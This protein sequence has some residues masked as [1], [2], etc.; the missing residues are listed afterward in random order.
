MELGAWNFDSKL[1]P[2]THLLCHSRGAMHS[3]HLVGQL[4]ELHF[5][6]GFHAGGLEVLRQ[7]LEVPPDLIGHHRLLLHLLDEGG[8]G[9]EVGGVQRLQDL[10]E[11]DPG[12]SFKAHATNSA[13]L[14][15]TDR[16]TTEQPPPKE[17]TC[18]PK[19]GGAV[20]DPKFC[21]LPYKRTQKI[22][23]PRTHS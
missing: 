9:R 15:L 7:R 16:G 23:G 8:E 3:T 10:R 12:K 17:D 19:G 4:I 20:F 6:A 22:S 2:H 5:A 11:A 13:I 21:L 18:P 1:P 14:L